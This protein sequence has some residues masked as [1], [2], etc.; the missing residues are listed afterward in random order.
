MKPRLLLGKLVT[1]LLPSNTKPCCRRTTGFG[2]EERGGG[3]F[4]FRLP[5]AKKVPR[6]RPSPRCSVE[7]NG[8]KT[9]RN[10]WVGIK[11]V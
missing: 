10:W 8:K 6:G 4:W 2:A 1:Q 5:P 11:A 9:G 7:E 3:L